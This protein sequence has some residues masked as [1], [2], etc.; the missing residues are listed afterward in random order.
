VKGR[1]KDRCRLLKDKKRHIKFGPSFKGHI[2]KGRSEHSSFIPST[3]Q[4]E[5]NIYVAAEIHQEAKSGFQIPFLLLLFPI[6]H[7]E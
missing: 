7:A 2:K 5:L 6:F 1:E 4:K 3:M